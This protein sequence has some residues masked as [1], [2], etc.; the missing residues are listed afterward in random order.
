MF[1][2]VAGFASGL[3]PLRP[4]RATEDDRELPLDFG[5]RGAKWE[6]EWV[7]VPERTWDLRDLISG[8]FGFVTCNACA[9]T[10]AHDIESARLLS[11]VLFLLLQAAPPGNGLTLREVTE[12]FRWQQQIPVSQVGTLWWP[13]VALGATVPLIQTNALPLLIVGDLSWTTPAWNLEAQ[14]VA[15]I[16]EEIFFRLWLLEAAR[17]AKLPYVPSLVAS[18]LLFGLWHNELSTAVYVAVLGLYWGHLYAQTR[19]VLV[20]IAMHAMWNTWAI[21][22]AALK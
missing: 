19:N 15:P 18:A 17:F 22:V 2:L 1:F 7:G 21:Y 12:R 11:T 14:I 20:T 3:V 13:L 8:S 16:C 9:Y 4:L 6:F 10:V 5:S